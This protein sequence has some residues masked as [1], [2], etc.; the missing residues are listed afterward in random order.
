MEQYR[1]TTPLSKAHVT[2]PQQIELVECLNCKQAWELPPQHTF[3]LGYSIYP[4]N[5]LY[6]FH[7]PTLPPRP[8][9]KK[10]T[11]GISAGETP[12]N[13]ATMHPMPETSGPRYAIMYEYRYQTWE[14]EE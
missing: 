6:M 13:E 1:C 10:N 12:N 2:S 14:I 8:P 7:F 4:K 9:P 11:G 5:L 3:I